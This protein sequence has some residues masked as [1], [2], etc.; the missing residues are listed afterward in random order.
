MIFIHVCNHNTHFLL[1]LIKLLRRFVTMACID[2]FFIDWERPKIFDA[3]IGNQ[4]THLLD[5]PSI[6]SSATVSIKY[7]T[8][9]LKGESIGSDN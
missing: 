4:R 2:I 5:T 3:G 9:M 6:T 1:Q 7:N 8:I